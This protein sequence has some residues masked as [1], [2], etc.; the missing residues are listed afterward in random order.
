MVTNGWTKISPNT[1]NLYISQSFP[2]GRV[3][4]GS[5]ST[6]S[7]HCTTLLSLYLWLGRASE[8][9]W[10]GQL[11]AFTNLFWA[12]A[13]LSCFSGI[14]RSFSNLL[15]TYPPQ[16]YL[17]SSLIILLF[18]PTVFY[19]LIIHSVKVLTDCF[20]Q[21]SVEKSCS[22]LGNLHIR[23]NKAACEWGFSKEPVDRSNNDNLEMEV[24]I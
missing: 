16:L 4:R 23:Q 13:W 10:D 24:E 21:T 14:C 11:E 8:V 1:W 18:T 7:R 5:P 9:A 22:A 2:R 6:L 19:C 20:W 15:W 3:C 12:C 17:L